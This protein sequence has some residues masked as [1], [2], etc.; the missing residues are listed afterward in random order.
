MQI[1]TC[2]VLAIA[3]RTVASISDQLMQD[4]QNFRKNSQT[5]QLVLKLQWYFVNILSIRLD[6]VL[7]FFVLMNLF[8]FREEQ[9]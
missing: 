2:S 7:T 3:R 4:F 1:I 6:F 9:I 5:R 8:N